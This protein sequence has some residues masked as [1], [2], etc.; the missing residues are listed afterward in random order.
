MTIEELY[1]KLIDKEFRDPATGSLFYPV[2]VYLYPAESEYRIRE[3][4]TNLEERLQRPNDF[5]QACI[6]DIFEL[7]LEYLKITPFG[8]QGT[9]YDLHIKLESE[10]NPQALGLLKD[11]ANSKEFNSFIDNSIK[12]VL[13]LPSPMDKAYVIL[14][15]FGKIFPYLRVNKFLS[16]FEEFIK[17]QY[18][19]IIFYP[20]VLKDN[21]SLFGILEDEHHYRS[22]YLINEEKA[23]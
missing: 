6:F 5:I 23:I 16:H 14:H 1:Q 12:K 9:L 19:L 8:K 20:G 7:F 18:K 17:D 3:E 11:D 4:I 21:L 10:K 2:Y 22:I 15:G 13:Q